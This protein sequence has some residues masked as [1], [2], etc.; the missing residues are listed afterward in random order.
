M[1]NISIEAEW[2]KD[3]LTE[4][5]L[6]EISSPA[7]SIHYDCKSAIN[8]C[9]QDNANVKM[10]Q[11]LKVRHKSLM[12]KMKNNVIALDFV[13]SEKNLADHFTK[14]CLRQWS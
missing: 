7:I 13:R 4:V 5:P 14:S 12:F 9:H 1:N 3:L 11:H 2:L 6:L 8:K 10:N